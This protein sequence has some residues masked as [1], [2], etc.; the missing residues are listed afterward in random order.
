[1]I[2]NCGRGELC[3]RSTNLYYA[4]CVMDFGV[5]SSLLRH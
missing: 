2:F 5:R 1:M 4:L 3:A